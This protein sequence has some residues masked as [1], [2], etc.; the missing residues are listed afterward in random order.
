M[1]CINDESKEAEAEIEGQASGGDE[2]GR[3]GGMDVGAA[4]MGEEGEEEE[5]ELNVS[6]TQ[7]QQPQSQPPLSPPQQP[8]QAQADEHTMTT[9]MEQIDTQEEALDPINSTDADDTRLTAQG[10][11]LTLTLP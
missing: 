1:T 6:S 11:N 10:D 4:D 7:P 3:D 2:Q 9:S 8:Q 5:E